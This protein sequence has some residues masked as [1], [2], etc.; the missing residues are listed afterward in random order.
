MCGE[1]ITA[2]LARV[3]QQG[4]SPRV[5]GTPSAYIKAYTCLGI[6]PACAGNTPYFC[7]LISN[8]GDHPRVCGEHDKVGEQEAEE[9][10]SSPRVRGTRGSGRLSSGH[11]GIIPACAGN[12]RRCTTFRG[13]GGDHPRVCGEHWLSRSRH[14]AF[15]GSSPR[16][17]GTRPRILLASFAFGIIPAC[18]G[19]TAKVIETW[20]NDW[21]HPRVCGEHGRAAAFPDRHRGSSPRVRG[22]RQGRVP[23]RRRDGIIPACAGNTAP[24]CTSNRST[25]DHPRVCGEHFINTTGEVDKTGSSPRVR[26]TRR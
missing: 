13:T 21:D 1:H 4:S 22:T 20:G 17:R 12:T 16:V 19:N 9:L 10:G 8:L 5:R 24:W 14:A 3:L 15:V 2:I 11:R 6:I 25:R 18:A 7:T 23:R 26:G